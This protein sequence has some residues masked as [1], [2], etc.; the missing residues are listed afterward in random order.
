MNG[1]AFQAMNL[2]RDSENRRG[3]VPASQ[4]HVWGPGGVADIA[5]ACNDVLGWLN[6]ETHDSKAHDIKSEGISM[7]KH[8]FDS[9]PQPARHEK[10][11]IA[12]VAATKSQPV[13]PGE[14]SFEVM[15]TCAALFEALRGVFFSDPRVEVLEVSAE[16]MTCSVVICEDLAAIDVQ[17]RI[18]HGDDGAARVVL[19]HRSWRDV[20]LFRKIADSVRV[21]VKA[22]PA[23]RG[24]APGLGADQDLSEFGELGDE[25]EVD[26]LEVISPLLD[27]VCGQSDRRR[28]AS[29]RELALLLQANPKC[30]L[31]LAEVIVNRPEVLESLFVKS[32]SGCAVSAL[33]TMHCAATMLLLASAA[34]A[35]HSETAQKLRSM[36]AGILLAGT[37]KLVERDLA[38]ALQNLSTKRASMA[39]A[40]Q[41]VLCQC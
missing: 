17:A 35:M 8:L 10:E 18:C 23:A 9:A 22:L 40:L 37:P 7:P 38:Q 6:K 32:M 5:L 19:S 3:T 11:L 24:A 4:C 21:A 25:E 12:Q 26:W 34:Q 36:T 2:P 41:P 31:Q 14:Y 16:A 33:A 15:S 20:V 29:A 30:R 13:R 27:Q 28:E 39:G 1:M